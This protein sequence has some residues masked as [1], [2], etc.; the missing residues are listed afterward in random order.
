MGRG[1]DVARL[2]VASL[3]EQLRERVVSREAKQVSG[4]EQ[5]GS[6]VADMCNHQVAAQASSRGQ[7]RPHP[8]QCRIA[9]T[10]LDQ[11]GADFLHARTR[12]LLDLVRM[13]LVHSEYPV[14]YVE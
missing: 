6:R 14:G 12:P 1:G 11:R 5:V 10:G 3:D 2:E 13:R 4:A 9:L 8:S 7:R